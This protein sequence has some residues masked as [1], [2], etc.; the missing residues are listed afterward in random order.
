MEREPQKIKPTK[1]INNKRHYTM[2]E[3]AEVLHMSKRTLSRKMA[4]RL[5]EYVALGREKFLSEVAVDDYYRRQVVH[6]KKFLKG[7]ERR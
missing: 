2:N 6:T 7:V 4:K 1:L 5:I 3:G